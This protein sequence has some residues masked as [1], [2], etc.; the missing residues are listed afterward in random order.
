MRRTLE[1]MLDYAEQRL[2]NGAEA[3]DYETLKEFLL[4]SIAASQLAQAM[5]LAAP[6]RIKPPEVDLSV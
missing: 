2:D 5:A 4:E 1:E 6:V 3:E